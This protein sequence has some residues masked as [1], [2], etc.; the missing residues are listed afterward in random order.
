MPIG[1]MVTRKGVTVKAKVKA[2]AITYTSSS[3]TFSYGETITGGTSSATA[4]I[5][6]D[7]G[8]VLLVRAVTGTFQDAETIT[9]GTSTATGTISGTPATAWQSAWVTLADVTAPFSTSMNRPVNSI[10]TMDSSEEDPADAIFGVLEMTGSATFAL[11]PGG[12]TFQMME[13]AILG[14]LDVGF[15]RTQTDRNGANTRTKYYVGGLSN[16]DDS[17]SITD[18]STF[19]VQFRLSDVY[20]SDPT[21]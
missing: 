10:T 3:G 18:E 8:T 4:K 9:G 12:T 17:D 5:V 20:D 1:D 16:A 14:N 6:H 7:S 15:Y 2:L 21:V 11:V 19:G 13:G